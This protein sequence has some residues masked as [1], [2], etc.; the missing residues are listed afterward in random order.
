M[1]GMGG[2]KYSYILVGNLKERD[3]F[4]RPRSLVPSFNICQPKFRVHLLFP[5]AYGMLNL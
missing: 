5:R 2:M 3:H 1:A 4:W